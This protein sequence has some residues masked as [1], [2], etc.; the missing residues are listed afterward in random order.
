MNEEVSRQGHIDDISNMSLN[1]ICTKQFL[2]D[3]SMIYEATLLDNLT[4]SNKSQS[5]L[6]SG[7]VAGIPLGPFTQRYPLNLSTGTLGHLVDELDTP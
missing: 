4:Y 5:G 1:S 3:I 2:L 6:D 7:H